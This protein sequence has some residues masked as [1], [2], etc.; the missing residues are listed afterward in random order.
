MRKLLVFIIIYILTAADIIFTYVGL[1]KGTIKEANPI[2]NFFFSQ[3]PLC[4]VIGVLL[5]VAIIL[6]FLYK[7]RCKVKWLMQAL[8][9]VMA[10][11]FMVFLLHSYWLVLICISVP[12]MN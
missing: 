12:L 11:K 5:V 2:M 1:Q 3:W 10:L 4:T 6:C 8:T 9:F 7:I